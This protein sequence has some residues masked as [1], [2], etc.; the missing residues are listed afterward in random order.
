[1]ISY[2]IAYSRF[3]VLQ[4]YKVH[5]FDITWLCVLVF[6]IIWKILIIGNVIVIFPD[7]PILLSFHSK[8]CWMF[9]SLLCDMKTLHFLLTI[10]QAFSDYSSLFYKYLS[11]AQKTKHTHNWQCIKNLLLRSILSIWHLHLR[12]TISI[13]I[14]LILTSFL[15]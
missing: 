7:V 10:S 11:E 6:N 14:L 4:N 12:S 15:F 2:I 3:P 13:F 9:S 5:S 1:M 8:C